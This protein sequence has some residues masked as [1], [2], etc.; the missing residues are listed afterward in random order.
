M[1]A[2]FQ[3]WIDEEKKWMAGYRK[4]TMRTLTHITA[5]CVI[6]GLALFF[7]VMMLLSG[8]VSDAVYGAISGAVFGAI[9]M[10]FVILIVSVG[11][12]NGRMERAIMS[13][14][15]QLNLS[16]AEQF[17]LASEMLEARG[18]RSKELAFESKAPNSSNPLPV[19][20]TVTEHYAYMK[21][22]SPLANIIRLSD[23][24]RI[25]AAQEQRQATRR[26]SQVK[27]IYTFNVYA[28][29]FFDREGESLGGF[30]FFDE[31]LR[32]QTMRML[33]Q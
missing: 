19:C 5:P 22:D 27:T 3:Q 13:A 2:N 31:N 4:K 29:C 12:S 26:G 10:G 9:I 25:E 11:A 21:G 32:N 18:D 20:V 7:G 1:E 24:D 14:V 17:Q 30:G 15:R 28:V 33:G 23:I 16:E 6:I 8:P